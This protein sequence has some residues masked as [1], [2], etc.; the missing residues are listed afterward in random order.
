MIQSDPIWTNLFKFDPIYSTLFKSDQV[1][2]SLIQF[3]QI[4]TNFISFYP[5]NQSDAIWSN[6]K[7]FY[8]VWIF[9][10]EAKQQTWQMTRSFK[11][12]C[13]SLKRWNCRGPYSNM[14]IKKAFGPFL[15]TFFKVLNILYLWTVSFFTIWFNVC[16]DT[17][18]LY[19]QH[20]FFHEFFFLFLICRR[21]DFNF[22]GFRQ[23][24]WKKT[25][26]NKNAT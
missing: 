12:D 19:I 13:L 7:Q 15:N 8:R 20:S 1:C 25:L 17:E 26:H 11:Q 24:S 9:K 6:L 14:T 16:H 5:N 4:W 2:S 3:D 21:R 18:R 23:I 10:S 22:L